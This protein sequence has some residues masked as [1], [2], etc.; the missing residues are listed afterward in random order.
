MTTVMTVCSVLSQNF[1][2]KVT[3]I[4][5]TAFNRCLQTFFILLIKV[6]CFELGW[7]H[8][9]SIVLSSCCDCQKWPRLALA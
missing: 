3:H 1:D 8:S 7:E 4:L 6:L 2:V 9:Q 5:A